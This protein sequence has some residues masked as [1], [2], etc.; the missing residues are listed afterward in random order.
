MNISRTTLNIRK[1][2]RIQSEFPTKLKIN[3]N[4]LNKVNFGVFKCFIGNKEVFRKIWWNEHHFLNNTSINKITM[5][6]CHIKITDFCFNFNLQVRFA[7]L[8]PKT[9]ALFREPLVYTCFVT[10]FKNLSSLD[11]VISSPC[12][13]VDGCYYA[14]QYF[15]LKSK[16]YKFIYVSHGKLQQWMRIVKLIG[17]PRMTIY[18]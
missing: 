14:S 8:R 7:F 15:Y 10:L 6:L 18:M 16:R 5:Y 4:S 17:G 12:T 3:Q 13:I 11:L 9:I 1:S 2:V